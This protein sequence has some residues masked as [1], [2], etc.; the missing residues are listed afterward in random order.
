ME[1]S[2]L[3][4]VIEEKLRNYCESSSNIATIKNTKTQCVQVKQGSFVT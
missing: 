3:K 4:R 1:A 2:F